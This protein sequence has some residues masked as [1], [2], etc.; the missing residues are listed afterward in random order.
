MWL[1]RLLSGMRRELHALG[2]CSITPA[3]LSITSTILIHPYS[4]KIISKF[5]GGNKGTEGSESW[6]WHMESLWL[7]LGHVQTQGQPYTHPRNLLV[8]SLQ[9]LTEGSWKIPVVRCSALFGD[10]LVFLEHIS[11]GSCRWEAVQHI[12]GCIISP[13]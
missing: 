2:S 9:Q 1:G 4:L 12:P 5:G 6:W 8:R 13:V 7:D 11:C 10:S 3:L